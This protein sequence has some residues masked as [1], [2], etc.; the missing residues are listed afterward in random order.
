MLLPYKRFGIH[1]FNSWHSLHSTSCSFTSR[2]SVKSESACSAKQRFTQVYCT[3]ND[4]HALLSFVFRLKLLIFSFNFLS[5][6]IC[7]LR[8]GQF[9]TRVTGITLTL[10]RCCSLMIQPAAA[11]PTCQKEVVQNRAYGSERRGSNRPGWWQWERW[12]P[13][14]GLC[15]RQTTWVRCLKLHF[16]SYVGSTSGTKS[17]PT[18]ASY[19]LCERV[20]ARHNIRISF[21]KI[22]CRKIRR[23]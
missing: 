11:T 14:D 2:D 9:C 12:T 22:S 21:Q 16:R 6:T 8:P 13:S 4:T 3:V 7:L 5:G 23:V 15:L 17:T 18:V 1:G 20:H 10:P 19:L